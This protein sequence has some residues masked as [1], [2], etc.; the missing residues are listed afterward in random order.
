MHQTVANILRTLLYTNPPQ[1]MDDANDLIDD[2]L[3]TAMHATRT[4]VSSTLGSS[5]GALVYSRDMF[6]DIPLIAD[7][8]LIQQ[9]REQIVNESLRRH[10]NKRRLGRRW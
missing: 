6:L 3:A 8:I 9:R 10:N 7:W 5:P 2:A 4:N 1:N